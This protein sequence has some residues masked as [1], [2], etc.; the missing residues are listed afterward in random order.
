M[1]ETGGHSEEACERAELIVL[2]PGVPLTAPLVAE[3]RRRGIP[4]TGELELASRFCNARI[5]A[6]TGTNGKTTV[7]AM[8]HAMIIACGHSVGL[9]GNNDTPLSQIALLRDQ[10]E[11]VVVEVSSYQLETTETFHPEI[12]V[13]LNIT[14]DHLSRH[15]TLEQYAAIKA[16]IFEQQQPGDSAVRNMDDPLVAAMPVPEKI[17]AFGFSMHT[18]DK[19]TVFADADNIY[20]EDMQ[21][22]SR[23]DNP[24]PGSHNL[25]NV[26]AALAAIRAGGFHWEKSLQ[27]LRRFKG[28][29]HRIEYVM[30]LE[31]VDYY[32][33][34]K[35]T[36]LESLRVALESFQRPVVLLAGGRGKGSNYAQ[37]SALIRERVKKIIA[38][39]ED[40]PL[41]MTAYDGCTDVELAMSMMDAVNRARTAATTGDVVLLSPACASF[42]MY[43]NFE[44]RG[45]DYKDCLQR[46]TVS[47][48]PVT[49]EEERA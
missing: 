12:A 11:W 32:N 43:D 20:F 30:S 31:G 37:L 40:A 6:V 24:L 29:E 18:S 7:T 23:A 16:R 25:Q 26:L 27:G 47:G 5:I 3:A 48:A 46:L 44:A 35:A 45:R 8:L 2:S 41:I 10:P 33:D 22:A 21:V 34:S 28:V 15:G 1:C 9:A 13:V 17:R 39:G 36:N 4:I 49:N 14:P 38:F 42:D 19:N